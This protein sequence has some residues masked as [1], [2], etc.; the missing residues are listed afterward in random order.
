MKTKLAKGSREK[1]CFGLQFTYLFFKQI[2]GIFKALKK[3]LKKFPE[4]FKK[5]VGKS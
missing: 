3:F 2:L 5:K 4:N 1:H